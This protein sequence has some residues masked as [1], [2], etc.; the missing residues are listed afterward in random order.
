[1]KLLKSIFVKIKE[2]KFCLNP[3]F[4]ILNTVFM[5]L[6]NSVRLEWD[7]KMLVS[8]VNRIGIDS[9]LTNIGKLF[10]KIRKSRGPKTEPWNVA[11]RQVLTNCVALLRVE[12][13]QFLST[14]TIRSIPSSQK[15]WL[16]S[17]SVSQ[18]MIAST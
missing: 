6:L 12:D 11:F 17:L 3:S 5:L 7:S 8:S 13:G 14:G 9:P 4:K 18:C 10:M 16:L 2:S 15:I 1:M